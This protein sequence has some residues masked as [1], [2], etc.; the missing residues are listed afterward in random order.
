[1][2]V[3]WILLVAIFAVGVAIKQHIQNAW[4][5][6]VQQMRQ[7]RSQTAAAAGATSQALERQLE[8][9]TE[10]NRQ[11]QQQAEARR[12]EARRIEEERQRAEEDWRIARQRSAYVSRRDNEGDQIMTWQNE[13]EA[14]E[15]LNANAPEEGWDL[16]VPVSEL[17]PSRLWR[18]IPDSSEER[19]GRLP[20]RGE[21]AAFM[22]Q[23]VIERL[24][25]RGKV[26]VTRQM[27]PPR[28]LDENQVEDALQRGQL[29]LEALLNPPL[30]RRARRARQAPVE[31]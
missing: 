27:N 10:V 18:V 4:Q 8:G 22:R 7:E 25:P 30:Q 19:G 2:L 20:G 15:W 3:I 24:L 28:L 29:A 1:M 6:D 5:A 11:L 23:G 17:T 31:E 12:I 9:L 21:L 26:I 14:T 16:I 13:A